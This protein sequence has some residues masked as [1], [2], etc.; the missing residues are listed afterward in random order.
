MDIMADLFI[1]NLSETLRDRLQGRARAKHPSLAKEAH[2]T[3]RIAAGSLPL[4]QVPKTVAPDASK[5]I[6]LFVMVVAMLYFGRAVL[7]PVTIALLLTFLL[8]PL[9]GLFRRAHLGRV[10][11]VLLS[12]TLALG[13]VLAIGGV[14]GSQIAGLSTDLP[15]YS[16][17]V[18]AKIS[19]VNNYTIG[20]LSLLV[21]R[22]QP[23]RILASHQGAAA[24]P[25]QAPSS[26]ARAAAPAGEQQVAATPWELTKQYLSPVLSPFATLGI[27]FVVTIFALLQRE[28][29]R[30]RLIR[31]LGSGDI[32]RTTAAM[33]EVGRRLT[34]Y[35]LTQ[36]SINTVFGI[37]I[38]VGLLAIGVPYPVLW[39]ILA[40]LLRFVPYV[41]S[42]IS[43]LLPI[44]LAAAIE[45]GWS[46][47]LFTAAFYLVAESVTGQVVEP[48]MYSHS[49]GLSPF[50]V[51]VAALFWS[52]L[53]GPIG[54]ILSTPL[55][56]CVVVLG[57]H[58]KRLEL[59]DVMLGDT[60]A[61]TPVE[62]FYQR[63]LA[64]DPDEALDQAELLLKSRS[65]AT[66]YDEVALKGMQ[67]AVNDAARGVLTPVQLE[68]VKDTIQV[69]VGSLE[70][71]MENP[72]AVSKTNDGA[73]EP[74][75]DESGPKGRD[76]SQIVIP[77]PDDLP[78]EWRAPSAVL[79]IAGRGPLDEPA[80]AMLAQLLRGRGIGSRLVRHGEVARDSIQT[81]D[82]TAVAMV[83]IADLD[84]RGSPAHLRYLLQRLRRR[85]PAGTPILIGLWPEED[86][87]L[88]NEDIRGAIGAD[89]FASSFED[90]VNAC[91]A[92]AR[93]SGARESS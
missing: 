14:I 12:V 2:E 4:N 78:E 81:L 33:D 69:L 18:E 70:T 73:V 50:S 35:F 41:G 92:V 51:V 16:A 85:F 7:I 68:S 30:D 43:A 25:T 90:V 13:L 11:S 28:D 84:I 67:L 57:R 64:G 76:K 55:T 75:A 17:A 53:W 22:I 77:A 62:S 3:R 88:K 21:D 52:W 8:A 19:S 91:L 54:L 87:T 65:L 47:A 66:Y 1:R 71:Q 15:Q 74:A 24:Q 86:P 6:T 40:A 39:G 59:L 38:G 56:L 45:P 37:V 61:L 44:S 9:V 72:A 48:M 23:R 10:P 60:P 5:A 31:V 63:I 32:H 58:V 79:S 93:R 34:R 36:L 42:T 80:S 46:M 27:V 82:V 20:R 26:Q 29:L 49:T 83:C 89:Y